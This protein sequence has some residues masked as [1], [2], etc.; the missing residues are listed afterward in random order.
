[1]TFYDEVAPQINDIYCFFQAVGNW[2]SLSPEE[3]IK[4]KRALDA[5][6][7]IKRFLFDDDL[8][9]SYRDFISAHFVEYGGGAGKP[10]TL[11]LDRAYL[12]G[13]IG[14]KVSEWAGSEL[15]GD[16]KKQRAAYEVV[17]VTMAKQVK[18]IK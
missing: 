1:L 5:S 4:R 10:A 3:I 11:L 7:Q 12:K 14:N 17:M 6:F 9:T 8:F 15:S 18:G 16:Y 13:M 2:A